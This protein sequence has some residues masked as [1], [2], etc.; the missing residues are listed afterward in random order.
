MILSYSCM[1]LCILVFLCSCMSLYINVFIYSYPFISFMHFY[2]DL[3]IHVFSIFLL[4]IPLSIHVSINIPSLMFFYHIYIYSYSLSNHI[5]ISCIPKNFN[6][7]IST[8][9]TTFQIFFLKMP[10]APNAIKLLGLWNPQN[11]SE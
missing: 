10:W 8:L 2:Q 7:A 4:C 6:Q 3:A 11:I 5:F 9:G 1:H